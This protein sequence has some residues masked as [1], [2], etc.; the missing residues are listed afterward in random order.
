MSSLKGSPQVGTLLGKGVTMHNKLTLKSMLIKKK[1]L[2][3]LGNSLNS[4]Q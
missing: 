2:S 4:V 3:A 1:I